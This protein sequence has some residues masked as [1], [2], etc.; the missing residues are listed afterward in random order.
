LGLQQR[1]LPFSAHK[2][3]AQAAATSP[4]RDG[5]LALRGVKWQGCCRFTL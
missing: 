3:Q 4:N 5:G 1:L 2:G